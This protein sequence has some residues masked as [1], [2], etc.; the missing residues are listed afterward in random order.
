MLAGLWTGL[1]G[2]AVHRLVV[3]CKHNK[4]KNTVLCKADSKKRNAWYV[5]TLTTALRY[6]VRCRIRH[7]K[8][9]SLALYRAKVFGQSCSRTPERTR[10]VGPN[11]KSFA[12]RTSL[13]PDC[14]AYLGQPRHSRQIP[15]A[16]LSIFHALSVLQL[17]PTLVLLPSS[18]YYYPAP[19]LHRLRLNPLPRFSS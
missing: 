9:E 6:V 12:F 17:L 2:I 14:A 8:Q 1:L 7:R 10:P 18:L 5:Q 15:I 19:Y 3:P 13:R 11:C 16:P 4:P